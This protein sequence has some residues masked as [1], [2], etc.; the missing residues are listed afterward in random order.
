MR[1]LPMPFTWTEN[2]LAQY[3]SDVLHLSKDSV[4]WQVFSIRLGDVKSKF[5]KRFMSPKCKMMLQDWID[6]KLSPVISG[7]K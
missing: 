5:G 1:T 7:S 2:S 6:P 3:A 4:K